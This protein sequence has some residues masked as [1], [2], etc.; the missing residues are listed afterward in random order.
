[1][2][3]NKYKKLVCELCDFFGM[4]NLFPYEDTD[5]IW[6]SFMEMYEDNSEVRFKLMKKN[7]KAMACD[8]LKKKNVDLQYVR[9]CI[10]DNQTVK[11]Y[12][13]YILDCTMSHYMCDPL[14][15]EEY[16]LFKEVFKDEEVSKNE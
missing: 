15:E 13:E 9:T 1:M 6:N 8:I 7:K 2:E 14:T 10:D 11:R 3:D 16:E 4:D 5:A 12:N